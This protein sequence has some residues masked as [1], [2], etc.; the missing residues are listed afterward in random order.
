MDILNDARELIVE[1]WQP[2]ARWSV[3]AWV[4]FYLTFLAYAFAQHGGYLFVDSANLVV[5]EGGHLLFGWFGPTLGIW[6]GTILNGRCRCSLQGISFFSDNWPA[7]LSAYSFFSRTGC[8]PRPT[9]R[10]REP[11]ICRW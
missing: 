8:I 10:T 5:H 9:W 3:W 2:L 11:R 6:G 4:V 7:L 1:D